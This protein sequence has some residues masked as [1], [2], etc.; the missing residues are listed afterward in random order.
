MTDVAPQQQTPELAARLT[1]ALQL[2]Q[3]GDPGRAEALY[4]EILASTAGS[5]D[6]AH[7]LG[8]A[9]IQRGAHEEGI[10]RIRQAI[11]LDPRQPNARYHL[12]RALLCRRDWP[13]AVSACDDLL[14]LQSQ[15]AEV[16]FLRGNA[17]QQLGSHAAAVDDYAEA[18]RLK[19]DFPAA[20]NNAGHS[21][22]VLRRLAAATSA[23]RR[24]LALQPAYMVAL[25]NLG[26]AL[27]DSQRLDEALRSFD[28]ALAVQPDAI[29]VLSN[30]GTALMAMK[31]CSE[32]AD[33]FARVVSLAPDFGAAVG[34]LL[35]ARRNCCDWSDDESLA[36][37]VVAAV[38]RG[39]M[40]DAPLSFVGVCD[41]A[42]LQLTCARTFSAAR[43]PSKARHPST[44]V[45]ITPNAHRQDRIRVAY[46]SGDF[47]EHAVSYLIAG[48]IEHHDRTRFETIGVGWGRGDG[49]TH[50]RLRGAF[51]RFIDATD[52]SDAE[53]VLRLR[54]LKVDIA[55]DL[56]GHT[57][58][59]RTE[60]FTSR[61][62]PVQVNY[63]G[64][65]GTSGVTEIDYILADEF[66]IAPQNQCHYSEK[67]VYLPECF[68]AND[69]QRVID[70]PAPTRNDL[71][72]PPDGFVWC[73]FHGSHK[74]TP[75]MFEVWVR[76]A[77][78]VPGSVLWLLGGNSLVEDNL[79]R[80][81]AARGLD[82]QRL[83]FAA[84][85]PYSRH[86]ARLGL[87]DLCLDTLPFNGGAT[88]SDALWAGVPVVTCA[89]QSFAARMS[90]SLLHALGFPELVAYS[91][92]DYERLALQLARAPERL[93]SLRR[94]LVQRRESSA[95]FDT[96][97]FC[98]HLEAAY[99][100]LL[101]RHARGE[102]PAMLRV[103]VRPTERCQSPRED[104]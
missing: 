51:E 103:P 49:P 90:G 34:S 71:G 91:S 102:P 63:L 59:Q 73:S 80:E 55:V 48:V 26:L 77:R 32:A 65:P 104:S 57:S 93:A 89:G 76:L 61:A 72:L 78:A 14:T 56:T 31:R 5:F 97:R 64:F 75:S 46:L 27:L 19:P 84:H 11:A 30:R 39:Q 23:F 7:L 87:A 52:V 60:I 54:D 33:S 74:I 92:S 83:V 98:R 42:A 41:S 37:R 10:A 53:I 99:T 43:Y 40:A 16:W 6:A 45:V 88:T 17:R 66:L 21:L 18:L 2:H 20:W 3:G 1:R 82:P 68:Q 100:A 35:Y 94:R 28:D 67:V 47:G 69:D 101:E 50:M 24:A 15:N 62:A 70:A 25:N 81:A 4:R 13:A 22:R 86:L 12:V 79:R 29:E 95:L 38:E 58:G 96:T 44:A 9:L 8:V 36:Q 85:L